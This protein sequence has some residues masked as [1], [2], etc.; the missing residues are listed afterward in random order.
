MSIEVIFYTQ[1]ASV[2]AFILTL[3]VLYKVLVNAKDATI[4]TLKQ[5]IS[6]LE[7]KNRD[8]AET[9]P[10]VLLQRLEQR[11]TRLES[12]LK[13]AESEKLPLSDEIDEL[14]KK[15]SESNNSNTAERNR[16]IEQLVATSQHAATVNAQ[17]ANLE[18]QLREVHGPYDQFLNYANAE[19]SPGRKQII[20][21]IVEFFGVE[22]V[23]ASTPNNLI[24]QFSLFSA[25]VKARGMHENIPINGGAMTGL[26]SVGIID[27]DDQLTL[28]GVSVFKTIAREL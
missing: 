8:L 2:V 14:K 7:T 9:S 1:L 11:A 3:F 22:S 23:I 4:E 16:L 24:N 21:E 27:K 20:T 15:L 26:R 12:E 17:K 6:F 10:D 19:V 5:Q 18:Q 25:Q 13:E 28:V